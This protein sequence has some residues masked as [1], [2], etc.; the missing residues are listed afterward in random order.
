MYYGWLNIVSILCGLIA[1][2]IPIINLIRED[3]HNSKNLGVLSGISIGSCAISLCIQMFYANHLIDI[4]DFTAIMDIFPTVTSV[5]M[6]LVI[7]TIVLNIMIY[8]IYNKKI[9]I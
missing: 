3:K 6:V 5:S 8:M 9:E 1:V 2:V 4:G 7:V